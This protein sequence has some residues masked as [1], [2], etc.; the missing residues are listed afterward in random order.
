VTG[1]LP[2]TVAGLSPRGTSDGVLLAG[3]IAV[4]LAGHIEFLLSALGCAGLAG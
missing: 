3:M 1:Y 2:V 4:P